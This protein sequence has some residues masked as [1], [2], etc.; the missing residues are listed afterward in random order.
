MDL[1]QAGRWQNVACDDW[2]AA[3][4]PTAAIPTATIPTA[5]IP[6]ATVP[7]Q[8][9]LVTRTSTMSVGI[10]FF[11]GPFSHATGYTITGLEHS[12]DR[13]KVMRVT[14]VCSTFG[15]STLFATSVY[16]TVVLM[17]FVPVGLILL[18]HP[19]LLLL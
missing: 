3:T 17:G 8:I 16:R 10:A 4:V 13:P 12:A 1:K 15:R 11:H 19:R 14:C 6:T 7:T 18:R 2:R 5:T 9:A